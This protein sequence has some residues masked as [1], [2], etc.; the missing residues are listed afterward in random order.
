MMKLFRVL[1]YIITTVI[2]IFSFSY[3]YQNKVEMVSVNGAVKILPKGKAEWINAGIGMVLR[4]GDKIKTGPGSG[5]SLFFDKNGNNAVGIDENS[6][7]IVILEKD[8]KIEIIDAS[9]YMM[10]TAIPKNSKFEIKTPTAVCGAR[11]T[12]MGVKGN[13]EN[14]EAAA[15]KSTIYVKNAKG[16]ELTVKEGFKRNID[17]LGKISDEII[18]RAEEIS[19]FNSWRDDVD[20]ITKGELRS[21]SKRKEL[22]SENI[23]KL[24][25]KTEEIVEKTDEKVTEKY[26]RQEEDRGNN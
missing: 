9:I 14:T 25:D 24:V 2:F 17:K 23:E 21:E 4:Q 10:L 20:K 26:T 19:R 1:L 6:E 7:V 8:E 3:A 13:K 11:G 5:C 16:E 15:Y 12:G 18:A 22:I